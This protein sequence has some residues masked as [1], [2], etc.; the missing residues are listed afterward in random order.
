MAYGHQWKTGVNSNFNRHNTENLDLWKCT[1]KLCVKPPFPIVKVQR[2]RKVLLL[3]HRKV[4]R[5]L[6]NGI[7]DQAVAKP[8]NGKS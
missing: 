2:H 5:T 3:Y 7:R 4:S 8:R 1:R 6:H